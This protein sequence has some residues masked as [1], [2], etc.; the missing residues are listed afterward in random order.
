MFFDY[1][2]TLSGRAN[3]LT[4]SFSLSDPAR[5]FFMQ[6]LVFIEPAESCPQIESHVKMKPVYD[7]R[8][9]ES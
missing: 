1:H 2:F 3:L 6:K 4:I 9:T 8:E 7:I 5:I